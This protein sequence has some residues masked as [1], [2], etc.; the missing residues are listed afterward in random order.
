MSNPS[1]TDELR[2]VERA[3]DLRA[4]GHTWE[5][6]AKRLDRET[7][8]VRQWP[9]RY[10]DFWASRMAIA[11]RDLDQET[12]GEARTVLRHHLWSENLKG[13]FEAARILLDHARR[14]LGPAAEPAPS[15]PDH[16]PIADHLEGLTH[17]QLHAYFE[18]QLARLA[19]E[20]TGPH[21][22]PAER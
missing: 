5:Q 7:E 19:E 21:D 20:G 18:S 6:V 13:V 2:D 12:I 11:Q 10:A 14:R 4:E 9:Q 15:V 22:G 1:A 16:V 17:D 3:I 8:A